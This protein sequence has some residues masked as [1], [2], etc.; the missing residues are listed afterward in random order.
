MYTDT[1][2]L[3][4]YDIEHEHNETRLWVTSNPEMI[5]PELNQTHEIIQVVYVI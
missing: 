5:D 1:I 2:V 3:N 4:N